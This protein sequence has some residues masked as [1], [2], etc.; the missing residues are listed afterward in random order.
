MG[1]GRRRE[2]GEDE[3]KG[4][5]CGGGVGG[6]S[7][8]DTVDASGYHSPPLLCGGRAEAWDCSGRVDAEAEAIIRVV[9]PS[10]EVREGRREGVQE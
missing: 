1:G 5:A 4:V 7:L 2:D 10:V 8:L 6:K 3:P 9:L